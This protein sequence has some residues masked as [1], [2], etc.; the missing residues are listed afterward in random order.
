MRVNDQPFVGERW[1]HVLKSRQSIKSRLNWRRGNSHLIV[2]R[3]MRLY[4]REKCGCV[5][6]EWGGSGTTKKKNYKNWIGLWPLKPSGVIYCALK[7][8]SGIYSGS[9]EF[10][11]K[12]AG[13]TC[14]PG[15]PLRSQEPTCP[16]QTHVRVKTP[17]AQDGPSDGA[18][19]EG[20]FEVTAVCAK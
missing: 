2:F 10:P 3:L 11:C 12:A 13:L 8:H 15:L 20:S 16:P 1:G 19:E 18:A 7:A 9:G 17:P 5:G 6:Q 4:S 14:K